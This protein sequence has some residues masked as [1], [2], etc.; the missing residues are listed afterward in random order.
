MKK[1]VIFLFA[2][3]LTVSLFAQ[4]E[5]YVRNMEK[6]IQQLDTTKTIEGL[7]RLANQ[8]ERIAAV[9]KT[10]WLPAYYQAYS[11]L[12]IASLYMNNGQADQLPTYLDAAQAA[13]DMAKKVAPKESEVHALQGYIYMARIW[14]NA[15]VN[16]P[17]FSPMA[18]LAFGTAQQLNPDNPRAD[19]LRGQMYFFTPAFWGG[20]A[21]AA[22][23]LL[24]AASKK[25]A[26]YEAPSSIH[27]LWGAEQNTYL[28]EQANSQLA[29]K[30]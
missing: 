16:G 3:I 15:M 11:Q 28:L 2:S 29:E 14:G 6:A 12:Q 17:K 13:M 19:F 18:H 25:F 26:A 22:Q 23:P 27:P 9:E 1:I 24:Q 5:K 20:G 7:Q 8:F 10:E 30:K 4:N 21:E